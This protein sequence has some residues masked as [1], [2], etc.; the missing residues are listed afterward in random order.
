MQIRHTSIYATNNALRTL[1]QL[2]GIISIKFNEIIK[3]HIRYHDS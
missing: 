1:L 3:Y 2:D